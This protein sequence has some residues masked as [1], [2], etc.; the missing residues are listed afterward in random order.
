MSAQGFD[1]IS[2]IRYKSTAKSTIYLMTTCQRETFDPKSAL[3]LVLPLRLV[4]EPSGVFSSVMVLP[5][6]SF[7]PFQPLQAVR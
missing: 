3:R 6:P 4:W 5:A 2:G 7:F 1:K